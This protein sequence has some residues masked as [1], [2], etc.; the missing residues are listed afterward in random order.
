[1]SD[2]TR[3]R[4]GREGKGIDCTPL[5]PWTEPMAWDQFVRRI[6]L[7]ATP[8]LMRR[9]AAQGLGGII[10]LWRKPI[11]ALSGLL[12]VASIAMLL[13]APKAAPAAGNPVVEALGLPG[14]WASWVGT[15]EEPSPAELME[16][17]GGAK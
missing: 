11:L 7:A 1:M 2:D 5:D 12:A 8:E 14:R 13:S 15:G 3:D 17:D 4:E 9:Q 6:R 16:A 10:V